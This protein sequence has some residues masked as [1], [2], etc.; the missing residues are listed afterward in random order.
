V[1]DADPRWIG[2]IE[3]VA[4][5]ENLQIECVRHDLR[6]PLPEHLRA[7]FD[8]FETDPPYTRQGIA[9]FVSRAVSALK[10]GDG[11]HGF[12]SCGPKS[13]AEM[14]E[15]QQDLSAMGLVVHE[16]TPAF[17]EYSGASILG[18]SSQMI[19]LLATRVTRPL[20]PD[21]HYGEPIHTGAAAPTT[22][23]YVCTQCK[24]RYRVGQGHP[25]V[26]IESLKAVGCGE[27]GN[28]SFRYVRRVAR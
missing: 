9:L 20:L 16:V 25:F 11:G 22:R 17:N 27:C 7:Q 26:T 14:L 10:P 13:P 24:T 6:D 21:A 8:T 19:H 1:L 18:G 28:A 2:F 23:L 5:S 4:Q 15:I 12:L 3:S